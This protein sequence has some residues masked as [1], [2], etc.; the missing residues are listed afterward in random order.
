MI[1]TVV[2]IS[3]KRPRAVH[4]MVT[5]GDVSATP[6]RGTEALAQG[7]LTRAR[8]RGPRYRRVF[9]DVYLPVAAPDDFA[10]R[11][12]A[13]YLLVAER[14]GVLAGYSAAVLLGADCAPLG[15]PA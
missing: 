8:L 3:P 6:F 10:T 4:G 15:A 7:V 13:A 2:S 5:L 9:P 14:G 11:S 1:A 12:R